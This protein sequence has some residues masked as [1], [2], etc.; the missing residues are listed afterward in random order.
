M[1]PPTTSPTTRYAP[2]PHIVCQPWS[3]SRTVTSVT[4]PV[5]YAAISFSIAAIQPVETGAAQQPQAQGAPCDHNRHDRRRR[6]RSR[7]SWSGIKQL[8]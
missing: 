8:E 5:S 6:F 7:G 2:R 1:P 3:L 4:S